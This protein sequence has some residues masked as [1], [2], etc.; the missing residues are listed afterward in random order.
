MRIEAMELLGVVVADVDEAV[1]TYSDRF[2]LDFRIFTP[3]V[4]YELVVME[5]GDDPSPARAPGGRLAMD[6]SGC[7][8]LVEVPGAEPGVR[9]I[10]FRVDDMDAAKEHVRATGLRVVADLM[11]G[12]VREVIFDPRDGGGVRLCLVQYEGNSFAEALLASP[13]P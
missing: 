11:A 5:V 9:N 4:D 2:G 12:T 6:T 1:A 8:E 7:F 3:G 13:R 10:H